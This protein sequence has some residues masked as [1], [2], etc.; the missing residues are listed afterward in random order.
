MEK[1]EINGIKLTEDG[2]S[3]VEGCGK[4][5]MWMDAVNIWPKTER[6]TESTDISNG[7][8]NM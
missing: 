7:R 4:S 6:D 1:V 8:T 3:G 5:L 2:K